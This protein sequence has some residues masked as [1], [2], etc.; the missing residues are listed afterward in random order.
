MISNTKVL[1][2][3][4]V[5]S[6]L[7]RAA[8]SLAQA[9]ADYQIWITA[10]GETEKMQLPVN[11][12]KLEVSIGTKNESV[13][14]AG[15]GEILILQNR[16]AVQI[17]FSSFFPAADF[18]GIKISGQNPLTLIKTLESWK[19]GT[20][21]VHLI[22]TQAGINLYCAIS[23]LDYNQIGG[24]VGTINY[25]ISLKEYREIAV[26]QVEVNTTTE[27]AT[28]QTEEPRVDNTVTPKT[29]TVKSGDCLWNIAKELYG[30][31][32][33]YTK[34]YEAN[35]DVIGGNP[36]LIYPGQTFTIPE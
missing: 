29:Y 21:P 13:Q 10:N 20:Q 19:K 9:V 35:K 17:K 34:I 3:A 1:G 7:T 22:I 18:P 25:S 15:L 11:P 26:R 28:V 27:T 36:N 4:G 33:D 8:R 14:I 32:A 2:A 12:E 24:D 23:N 5:A 6:A 31:G 30:N 16:P